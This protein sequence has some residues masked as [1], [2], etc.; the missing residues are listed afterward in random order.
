MIVSG[1]SFRRGRNYELNKNSPGTATVTLIDTTSEIDP[2]NPAYAFDP[3]TPAAIA[4]HNPVTQT[5]HTVFRGNISRLQYQ[6]YPSEK[7]AVAT[8]ELVDGLDRLARTEM[9]AGQGVTI[10]WGYFPSAAQPGD[11]FFITDD[12]GSAVANRINNVLNSAQWPV[13]L[14]EIFSGNVAL[15]QTFYAY[16]TPALNVILDAADA[17][18]PGVA[19]FYC[20]KDGRATFHGRLA[21]FNPDDAQYHISK[22]RCGDTAAVQADATRALIFGLDYDQDVEKNINTAIST[23]KGIADADIAGQRVE[24]AASIAAYGSRSIS[25]DNLLTKKDHFDNS[26]ANAAT[27]KFATYYVSNYKDPRTRVNRIIFKRLDP[28]HPNA[29]RVWQVMCNVDISDII[30]LKTTHQGGGFDE[31]FYVEGITA[32][33]RP[34]SDDFDDVVMHLDVSPRAYY[35]TNPGFF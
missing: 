20:Q 28:S 24:N 23:P 15:Q 27:K 35:N 2:T 12:S 4:L 21:R 16:R 19:N 13:G 9:N 32:E 14:R 1:W 22:W 7:Y 5:D 34:L 33:A 6:L 3:G 25:F 17:E 31:D 26:G 18:F 29:Q 30:R 10:Q 8:L 11:L